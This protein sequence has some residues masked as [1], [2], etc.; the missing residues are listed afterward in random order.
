[1]EASEMKEDVRMSS[2]V[3]MG[4]ELIDPECRNRLQVRDTLSIALV[5]LNELINLPDPRIRAQALNSRMRA[6]D[7]IDEIQ[8]TSYSQRLVI[9]R[10][11]ERDSLWR[12]LIDP[13]MNEPFPHLTAW[14]A[15]GFM[16]SCRRT[17]MEAHSDLKRLADIPAEKLLCIPKDNIK[18]LLHLSTGTQKQPDVIDASIHMKAPDF[19]EKIEKEY[20]DQH[21]ERRAPLVLRPG[22]SDRKAILEWVEYA[23][24]HDIAGNMTEA[25]VR[26]CEMALDDA[27]L[28]EELKTMPIPEARA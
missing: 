13:R 12:L 23:M 22:R 6:L 2:G 19:D 24:T 26:A 4:P 11:F 3:V 14:L 15:S 18:A 16:G 8:P 28:D 5:D 17:N 27:R 21:I 1:L 7:L 10:E 20:P 25:I 9:I